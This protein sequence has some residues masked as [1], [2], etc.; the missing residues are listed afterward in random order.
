MSRKKLALS[1]VAVFTLLAGTVPA[2]AAGDAV[3]GEK[4]MRAEA[5]ALGLVRAAGTPEAGWKSE[6]TRLLKRSGIIDPATPMT[7]A[8]AVALL[9]D[10]GLAVTSSTPDREVSIDRAAS[11]IRQAEGLLAPPGG[12][13]LSSTS[14]D[15]PGRTP[16]SLDDCFALR[17]HGACVVC[18]RETGLSA[19]NC[20]KNC[21]VINRPSPSEPLP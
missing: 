12:A 13:T 10:L 21:F 5:F 11:F 8:R 14:S 17:N 1:A 3:A 16:A 4:I 20:A 2:L 18:C 15:D 6:A 7:E 9:R 19:N